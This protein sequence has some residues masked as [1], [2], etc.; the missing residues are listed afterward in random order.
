LIEHREK[1]KPIKMVDKIEEAITDEKPF[2]ANDND[3]QNAVVDLKDAI[4]NKDMDEAKEKINELDSVVGNID[5]DIKED[6]TELEDIIDEKS[7]ESES[8]PIVEQIEET[9]KEI[10]GKIKIPETSSQYIE[11]FESALNDVISKNKKV[12]K[13]D[14]KRLTECLEWIQASIEDLDVSSFIEAGRAFKT[15]FVDSRLFNSIDPSTY[16][17]FKN[18]M[19]EKINA[20]KER[21]F[22]EHNIPGYLAEDEE[23]Y[24]PYIETYV[25][26]DALDKLKELKEYDPSLAELYILMIED[27]EKDMVKAGEKLG[28][29]VYQKRKQSD[30]ESTY[31]GKVEKIN[32]IVD[33][34]TNK[35]YG[36]L[37]TSHDDD[38]SNALADV[39][40]TEMQLMRDA[41]LDNKRDEANAAR[42]RIGAALSDYITEDDL[43]KILSKSNLFTYLTN[44]GESGTKTGKK[45]GRKK[46]D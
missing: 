17:Q 27:M 14:I 35:L 10:E 9:N 4:E 33:D 22:E 38:E 13:S 30:R 45:K 32:D 3:F 6:M 29:D 1:E 7:K 12:H 18:I 8:N 31:E 11:L 15:L 40:Y 28:I 2:L 43:Y 23:I 36:L 20:E 25:S 26:P 34:V 21:L 19:D 16:P 44:L 41:V 5:E 24:M 37:N 42:D 39:V 46:K